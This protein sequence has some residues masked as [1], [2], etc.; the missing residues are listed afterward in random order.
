M[1]NL[2]KLSK[3]DIQNKYLNKPILICDKDSKLWYI[4]SNVYSHMPLHLLTSE[5]SD[6]YDKNKSNIDGIKVAGVDGGGYLMWIYFGDKD[7]W[8]AYGYE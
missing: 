7:G 4:V 1:S 8:E 3:E 6:L 5:E 2:I